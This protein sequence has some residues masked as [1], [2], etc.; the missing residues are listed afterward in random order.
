MT[1]LEF[2]DRYLDRKA[3]N[4]S[5]PRDIR[6]LIGFAFIAG[7]YVLVWQFARSTIPGENKDLIRD[8]ML[9]LGPPIGL[10]VGAMFRSDAKEERAAE[11][12]G[13]AFDAIR[14]TAES[15]SGP[16]GYPDDPVNVKERK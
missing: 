6:Q 3:R 16:S 12:T 10:I 4:Q 9:T 14:T 2:L 1:L 5:P 8:A 11:N 15:A 13:K 7:Y